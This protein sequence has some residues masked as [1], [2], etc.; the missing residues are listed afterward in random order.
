MDKGALSLRREEP[1]KITS[2][3]KVSQRQ[4]AYELSIPS[5]DVSTPKADEFMLQLN[6][7]L[8]S[9][10]TRVNRKPT[11]CLSA[12]IIPKVKFTH[13]PKDRKIFYQRYRVK[14]RLETSR[15]A[16]HNPLHLEH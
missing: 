14:L 8:T 15:T 6:S 3:D 16:R 7:G 11:L 5:D 13:L 12:A 10:H 4:H 1:A 9:R 2:N